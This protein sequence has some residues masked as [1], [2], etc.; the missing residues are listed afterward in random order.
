MANDNQLSPADAAILLEAA[1][2][3]SRAMDQ[4]SVTPAVVPETDRRTFPAEAPSQPS[5]SGYH[6]AP[7]K[8]TQRL[9][10]ATLSDLKFIDSLQ[11]KFGRSLGFLPTEALTVNLEAGNVDLAMENDEPAGY[12]LCRPRL[13]WQPLLGSIVQAAVCMDAQRRH[14]GL[15]LL[16][17]VEE[18]ARRAG[19]VALQANCAVGVEANE[20]WQAAGFKPIAHLTPATVSGR[21]IIC[22]R[23]PLLRKLPSWFTQLPKQAGGRGLKVNSTRN[24]NR[25]SKSLDFAAKYATGKVMVA[26]DPTHQANGFLSSPDQLQQ[27]A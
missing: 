8:A 9:S 2:I 18:R 17:Q 15:A 16:L 21:E 1:E 10:R 5:H 7:V 13:A 20:F 27:G 22:W 25:D 11:K 3:Q 14:H 19:Q 12:L 4:S 23:K 6:I 26:G 24:I